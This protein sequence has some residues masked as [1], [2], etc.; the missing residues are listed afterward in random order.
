MFRVILAEEPDPL[1]VLTKGIWLL[2][3]KERTLPLHQRVIA[4]VTFQVVEQTELWELTC[5]MD[6]WASFNWLIVHAKNTKDVFGYFPLPKSNG[7]KIA[8]PLPKSVQLVNS[9]P[10]QQLP[11]TDILLFAVQTT[12]DCDDFH[13]WLFETGGY[14]AAEMI[15]EKGQIHSD[16]HM[17]IIRTLLDA[18]R[19]TIS[20]INTPTEHGN[21]PL[22]RTDLAYF[23]S[24]TNI[25]LLTLTIVQWEFS[26]NP[27]IH[28]PFY[29]D[30][31]VYWALQDQQT[32]VNSL[33]DPIIGNLEKWLGAGLPVS[34]QYGCLAIHMAFQTLCCVARGCTH[35]SCLSGVNNSPL[36]IE[37][38]HNNLH[39]FAS[40]DSAKDF[41][42]NPRSAEFDH[43]LF[44]SLISVAIQ[45][46]ARDALEERY[47]RNTR[48]LLQLFLP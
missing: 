11:E 4:T 36:V 8:R 26:I 13:D 29:S 41:L 37:T 19:H 25:L 47:M 42:R 16:G 22:L 28:T 1:I 15:L 21:T 32:F 30:C 5:C 3:D 31:D 35:L 40:Q 48:R 33:P 7:N 23:L 12:S 45:I 6:D 2:S 38:I 10:Q 9:Q 20:D 46:P 24:K 17:M 14:A 44:F 43:D 39:V 34:S 18:G 27:L